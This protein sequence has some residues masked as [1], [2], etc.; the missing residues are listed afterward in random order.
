MSPDAT[1]PRPRSM[2]PWEVLRVPSLANAVIA[3]IIAL[4]IGAVGVA[5]V[6]RQPATYQSAA[7]ILL[8]HRD[9]RR[10]PDP[11]PINR[12]NAL[13]R[14]YAALVPTDEI[15][16]QI[17]EDRGISKAKVARQLSVGVTTDSL[18]MYPTAQA[19]S[20]KA[21][22]ELCD[23]LAA[24]LIDFVDREQETV[25]IDPADRVVLRLVDAAS[26]GVKLRPTSSDAVGALALFG[27][28][29]AIG[30]Y[31]VLQLVT[32]SRRLR[33]SAPVDRR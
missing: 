15:A 1:R 10:V 23:A 32:A 27:G 4:P 29:G 25:G 8:D 24:E 19:K 21:S 22:R 28:V 33:R 6:M 14:T 3:M 30:V 5:A 17:A 12:L 26:D 9:V 11:A 20:A 16:G 13:R 7:V 2:T 18:I 31:V